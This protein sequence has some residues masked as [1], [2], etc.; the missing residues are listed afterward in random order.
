MGMTVLVVDDDNAIADLISADLT[1]AGYEV[2][3]VYRGY[4]AL[5]RI[6]RGE[7]DILVSD[8]AMPDMDGCELA[9]RTMELHPEALVFLMTG[10]GYDPNHILVR[11]CRAGIDGILYKPFNSDDLLGR[12]DMAR[13][14]RAES[15]RR[16]T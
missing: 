5:D 8:I 10:F 15:S 2:T 1:D 9:T 3:T 7:V 13:K 16:N 11:S 14:H 12:I 6:M 4:D